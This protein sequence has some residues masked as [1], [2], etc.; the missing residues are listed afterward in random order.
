MKTFNLIPFIIGILLCVSCKDTE[1][2]PEI[3]YVKTVFGGCNNI[4]NFQKSND[5]EEN[6]VVITTTVDTICVFVGLNYICGAPFKTQCNI[7]DD[8]I[9]MWITDTC[10]NG[11]DCY[12]RCDCYYT[13]DFLFKRKGDINYR[14]TVELIS[15]REGQSKILSEGHIGPL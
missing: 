12:Q 5:V 3:Q 1:E 6:Q 2:H 10:E 8:H 9:R 4:A 14:Y 13:F 7:E 11:M 15:P